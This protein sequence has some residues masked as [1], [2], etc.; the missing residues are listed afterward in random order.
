MRVPVE[1]TGAI[2]LVTRPEGAYV[3]PRHERE[4]ALMGYQRVRTGTLMELETQRNP[5]LYE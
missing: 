4:A 5:K 2:D 3:H 1:N